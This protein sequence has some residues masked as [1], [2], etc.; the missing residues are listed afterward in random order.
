MEE[1]LLKDQ[2]GLQLVIQNIQQI[3]AHMQE[4]ITSLN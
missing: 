1:N 4:I 2:R 3:H